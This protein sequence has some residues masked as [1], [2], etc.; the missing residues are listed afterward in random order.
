MIGIE[1]DK[2]CFLILKARQLDV[3]EG[4]E[5]ADE[6]PGSN[7]SD[8]NFS[9]VLS[10]DV[11]DATEEELRSII[12]DLNVDQQARLVA[13]AWVGRGDFDRDEW[14]EAIKAAR[15]EATTPTADYLLGIPNLGDLLAEGLAAFDLSCVGEEG[16]FDL[17]EGTPATQREAAGE[18]MPIRRRGGTGSGD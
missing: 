14:S 11:E 6:P 7:M 17:P 16:E 10:D 18:H 2:V 3:K 4:D 5:F 12:S 9:E 13:L 15:E 8:D 1:L